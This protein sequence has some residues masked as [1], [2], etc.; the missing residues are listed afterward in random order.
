[1]CG[2]HIIS[3]ATAQR[4]VF[5]ARTSPGCASEC[6]KMQF[7]VHREEPET[8]IKAVAS[9]VLNGYATKFIRVIKN[10]CKVIVVG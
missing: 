10:S 9:R 2:I 1:M 3:E 4:F 5:R 7:H 6:V 8:A